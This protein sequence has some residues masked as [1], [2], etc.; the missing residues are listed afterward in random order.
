VRNS[1]PVPDDMLHLMKVLREDSEAF[2]E[3]ER[4]RW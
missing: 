4:D 2:T 1:A 3:R